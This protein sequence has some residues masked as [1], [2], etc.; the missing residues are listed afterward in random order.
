MLREGPVVL[1]SA[2]GPKHPIWWSRLDFNLG[3][4]AAKPW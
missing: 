2:I 4:Q 3:K 1:H